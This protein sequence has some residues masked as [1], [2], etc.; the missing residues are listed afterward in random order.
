MDRIYLLTRRT[1][2][3]AVFACPLALLSPWLGALCQLFFS[4]YA[5]AFMPITAPLWKKRQASPAA[6]MRRML[7]PCASALFLGYFPR[8]LLLAVFPSMHIL[9]RQ[10]IDLFSCGTALLL[11][12]QLLRFFPY[13]RKEHACFSLICLFFF[14]A[15]MLS[16]G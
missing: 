7:F 10:L 4:L 8:F 1:L 11:Q 12:C 9:T 3:C 13:E 15:C 5:A 2:L 16:V 14:I 6:C